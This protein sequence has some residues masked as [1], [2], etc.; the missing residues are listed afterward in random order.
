MKSDIHTFISALWKSLGYETVDFDISVPEHASHGDFST[1]LSLVGAK[2]VGKP[3]RDLA[4]QVMERFSQWKETS[5]ADE[6]TQT[7][8]KEDQTSAVPDEVKPLLRDID[9][10]ELAGPG[11]VNIFLTEAKLV[12]QLSKV[13]N[14]DQRDRTRHSKT[15]K[16]RVMV[17]FAHPNTH[18]QFHIGHLRNLTTGESVV[19]LLESQGVEVIRAN[20]QGDVGLHI[21]KALWG[22]SVLVEQ[23][24]NEASTHRSI[25]SSQ[26]EA[27]QL[28][29]IVSSENEDTNH[30]DT[31]NETTNYESTNCEDTILWLQDNLKTISE[32]SEFLGR[33]YATGAGAYE[34]DEAA[35]KEIE[36]INKLVYAR[37]P[38]IYPLYELTRQWSLDSFEALYNRVGSRFDRYYFESQTYETGREAV[39]EGLKKGIFERSEGAVIFPGEKFG[40]H[41]RVFITSAGNPTYE[42]KDM[43]LGRLQ[44]DEYHPDMIIHCVASE[45]IGYFQVIFEALAQLYPDTRG[46]EHHLVYGWV[47]LKEGKMSSR[48]GNVVLGSWLLDETKKNIRIILDT[49][50]SNYTESEQNEVTEKAAIAAVKYGFLKV[51]TAQDIA[52]DIKESIN[53][54]GDSGPYLL[55]TYARCRSVMRKAVRNP[56]LH[57]FMDSLLNAKDTN[58]GK[59][60]KQWSNGTL[61]VS[62][63]NILRHLVSFD[64]VVTRAAAE[65]APSYVCTYLYEL[66]G[67]FNTFYNSS[68]ILEAPEGME[69]VQFRLAITQAVATVLKQGLYLLGIETVERM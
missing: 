58:T 53:I 56:L 38:R 16:K 34:T 47:R 65:Y 2:A 23:A 50:K 33:A 39:A 4:L 43:G 22:I 21:G 40:L 3:P 55:Y 59:T 32:R 29:G 11:F 69:K 46:K 17:E 13:L 10:L 44:F 9:H 42:A 36:D 60:M 1:N 48:S 26:A 20:Y 41:N 68:P 18:K 54:N 52:F 67:L 14:S 35:K 66:A 37:D 30:D 64:D 31:N 62:E 27:S 6:H 8:P 45:Q 61:F 15:D 51:S 5:E 49:N 57:G 25:A 19:R 12:S 7:L 63:R 28:R 24:Q